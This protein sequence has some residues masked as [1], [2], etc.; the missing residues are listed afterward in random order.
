MTAKNMVL[1]LY[2]LSPFIYSN[3]KIK[4]QINELNCIAIYLNDISFMNIFFDFEKLPNLKVNFDFP[5]IIK[6]NLENIIEEK[7]NNKGIWKQIKFKVSEFG[8]NNKKIINLYN[9][10]KIKE[11]YNELNRFHKNYVHIKNSKNLLDIKK[12]QEMIQ[13][14]ALS[15]EINEEDIEYIQNKCQKIIFFLK[16][17]AIW[18]IN[19]EL[20]Q[21]FFYN[22]FNYFDENLKE[23]KSDLE[24]VDFFYIITKEK[25]QNQKENNINIKCDFE[26]YQT[27]FFNFNEISLENFKTFEE[28][29]HFWL[30]KEKLNFFEETFNINSYITNI[31][32]IYKNWIENLSNNNIFYKIFGLIILIVIL[33]SVYIKNSKK[34]LL[35]KLNKNEENDLNNEFIEKNNKDSTLFY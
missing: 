26:N 17:I 13:L 35:N 12:K 9:L 28:R 18:K 3:M 32:I 34:S 22:H 14:N 1:F 5:N 27:Y 25:N 8:K 19:I 15:T 11:L 30:F 20:F 7:T 21:S 29:K 23:N 16:L 31:G 10:L 2:I 33:V 4:K 24:I 6:R